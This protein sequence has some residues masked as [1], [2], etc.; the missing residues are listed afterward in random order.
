M[1]KV[2]RKELDAALG[3]VGKVVKTRTTLPVLSCVKL[4]LNGDIT[5]QA[6]DLTTTLKQS[7]QS[8]NGASMYTWATC[9]PYDK[10]KTVVGVSASDEV[11]LTLNGDTLTVKNGKTTSKIR[12][13]SIEDY[14]LIDYGGFSEVCMIQS[15]LLIKGV[16]RVSH[17]ANPD[18]NLP[19]VNSVYLDGMGDGL[20]LVSLDGVGVMAM[21][22]TGVKPSSAFE[23][24]LPLA[25]T[26]FLSA[27]NG[28]VTISLKENQVMFSTGVETVI[29]QYTQDKYPEYNRLI[30]KDFKFSILGE[31]TEMVQALKVSQ[32]F[33][34]DDFN[35]AVM[36]V[37]PAKGSAS[38]SSRSTELGDGGAEVSLT[39]EGM[40][41]D[42]KLMF[43]VKYMLDTLSNAT[44]NYLMRVGDDRAIVQ[45]ALQDGW[46]GMVVF[47]QP[48]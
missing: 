38:I 24:I 9:V 27:L 10:F 22:E 16:G 8:E 46:T 25:S 3:F 15:A 6:T 31:T 5:I 19:K 41:I 40:D 48:K 34:K 12:C 32:V 29:S 44:A 42:F 43:N 26:S 4:D 28:L 37:S 11:E 17:A 39:V 45:S 13:L 23:V 7:I 47:M 18:S 2:S 30:P 20:N 21:L 36:Q 1:A 33:G 14:P 35:V